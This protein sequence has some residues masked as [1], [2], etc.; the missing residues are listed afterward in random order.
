MSSSPM[1]LAKTGILKDVKFT[2]GLFEETLN[3][4][5]FLKR[6]ILKDSRWYT[7]KNIISLQRLILPLESLR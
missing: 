4:F 5:D 2:S 3:E 1:L 6:K 7:M